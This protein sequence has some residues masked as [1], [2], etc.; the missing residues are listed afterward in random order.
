[1][2]T[3]NVEDQAAVSNKLTG[4]S[5]TISYDLQSVYPEKGRVPPEEWISFLKEDAKVNFDAVTSMVQHTITGAIL[6]EFANEEDYLSALNQIQQDNVI[7]AKHEVLVSG[8]PAGKEIILVKLYNVF[9]N[10]SKRSVIVSLHKYGRVVAWGAHDHEDLPGI[11]NGIVSVKL[12]VDPDVVLPSYLYDEHL[13]N[14]IEVRSWKSTRCCFKCFKVG[15]LAR[16]CKSAIQTQSRAN[17]NP[18]WSKLRTD[19]IDEEYARLAPGRQPQ[20]NSLE[21]EKDKNPEMPEPEKDKNAGMPSEKDK[22]AEMP[23][24]DK[25][26]PEKNMKMPEMK[27]IDPDKRARTESDPTKPREKSTRPKPQMTNLGDPRTK[28]KADKTRKWAESPTEAEKV[29]KNLEEK[30]QRMIK[31]SI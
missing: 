25:S 21:P 3:E 29:M 1:M 12:E 26:I 23:E 30:K 10:S 15:H 7:W 6:V 5:Y 19:N 17:H 2:S 27:T 9:A 28:V 22:N 18:R 8:C 31:K 16:K 4:L 20:T 14:T 13:E 24:P 11:K